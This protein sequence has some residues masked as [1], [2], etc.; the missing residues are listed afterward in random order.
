MLLIDPA[1]NTQH[2]H[3]A[4]PPNW[5]ISVL[6]S[7]NVSGTSGFDATTTTEPKT[8]LTLKRNSKEHTGSA[9]NLAA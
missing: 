3:A 2:C 1:L 7:V 4:P 6:T 9:Q 5:L 8:F